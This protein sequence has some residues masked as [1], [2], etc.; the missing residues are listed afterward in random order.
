VSDQTI[1]KE[2][3][4]GRYPPTPSHRQSLVVP[5]NDIT[6]FP[7]FAAACSIPEWYTLSPTT[8][9]STIASSPACVGKDLAELGARARPEIRRRL[10][11]AFGIG[12]LSL[13]RLDLHF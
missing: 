7:R 9:R 8:E 4:R 5:L 11:L 6:E 12:K 13:E 2:T 1:V 3:N 10:L